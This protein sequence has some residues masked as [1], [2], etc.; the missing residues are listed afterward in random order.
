MKNQYN[1]RNGQLQ[2]RYFKTQESARGQ[3]FD[4]TL[5]HDIRKAIDDTT[6]S[7]LRSEN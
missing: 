6:F 5:P 1:K 2:I 7:L 4:C 3:S